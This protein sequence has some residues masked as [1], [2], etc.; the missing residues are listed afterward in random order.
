MAYGDI[1]TNH[2]WYN[3]RRARNKMIA[4]GT[5]VLL[6]AGVAFTLG[7]NFLNNYKPFLDDVKANE[8]RSEIALSQSD[9]NKKEIKRLEEKVDSCFGNL[10]Q[11]IADNRDRVDN[12]E[13]GIYTFEN[14]DIDGDGKTEQVKYFPVANVL[15]SPNKAPVNAFEYAITRLGMIEEEGRNANIG[16]YEDVIRFY[17]IMAGDKNLNAEADTLDELRKRYK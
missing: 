16:E 14:L 17:Q 8:K 13:R 4:V 6:S 2:A 5:G 11:A 12:L 3:A 1:G 9:V 15:T 7:N 10:I